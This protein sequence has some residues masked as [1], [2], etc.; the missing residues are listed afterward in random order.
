MSA[1]VT[2][3]GES[4]IGP[5]ASRPAA[6]AFTGVWISSDEGKV[7][8][9]NGSSWTERTGGGVAWAFTSYNTN[10][11]LPATN[12]SWARWTGSTGTLTLPNPASCSGFTLGVTNLTANVLTVSPYGSEKIQGTAQSVTLPI[13]GMTYWFGC[14][15]TD[16]FI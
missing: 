4:R 16:W 11:A 14:D 15:G 6:A 5:I 8:Y 3:L 1:Q 9:S 7:Y 10:S 2:V 13:N 12:F